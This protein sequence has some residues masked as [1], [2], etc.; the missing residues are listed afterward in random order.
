MDI[1]LKKEDIITYKT[2]YGVI[3][4]NNKIN[5][6]ITK[7]ALEELVE[8][9][10]TLEILQ[11]TTKEIIDVEPK[12][13]NYRNDLINVSDLLKISLFLSLILNLFMFIYIF[14]RNSTIEFHIPKESVKYV[15]YIEY[16]V[17][18]L[19]NSKNNNKIVTPKKY[20]NKNVVYGMWPVTNEN[21]YKILT[22]S[23]LEF[24]DNPKPGF[25]A[26]YKVFYDINSS[27][28]EVNWL[29]E[30]G[31][32][33]AGVINI[34]ANQFNKSKYFVYIYKQKDLLSIFDDIKKSNVKDKFI[35]RVI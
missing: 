32:T 15:Q 26:V 20:Y 1:E 7:D 5:L 31:Y 29:R 21:G 18:T 3:I 11:E 10:K 17:D 2:E 23:H 9:C 19:T 24:Y 30:I 8:D 35:Q 16:D 34:S 27:L 12:L 33:N 6:S 13:E 25:Y 28:K 14:T 22:N 4:K